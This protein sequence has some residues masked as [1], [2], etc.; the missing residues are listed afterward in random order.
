MSQELQELQAFADRCENGWRVQFAGAGYPDGPRY[1]VEAT[2]RPGQREMQGTADEVRTWLCDRARL[3][4]GQK[5]AAKPPAKPRAIDLAPLF[6]AP[7][8][9][10]EETTAAQQERV[11]NWRLALEGADL[12]ATA[13]AGLPADHPHRAEREQLLT[14]ARALLNAVAGKVPR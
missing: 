8:D 5:A 1:V 3:A 11:V 4:A 9:R 13:L 6:H 12:V 2:A 7:P 10:A 14:A